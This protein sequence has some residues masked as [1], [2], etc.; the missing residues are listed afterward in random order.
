MKLRML[1][2]ISALIALGSMQSVLADEVVWGN[3]ASSGN[4]NLEAF[5]IN[6]GGVATLV[7][8]Q[9]FLV[10]NLTARVDNGRGVAVLGNT[11]YYTT[12]SS[13]DIYITDAISHADGGILVST[14]FPGIANVATDGTYIYASSYETASGVVNRYTQAG[15]AAGS[16][17]VGTGFGRDGF[18]V[19]NNPFLDGGATT[20]ISNRGDLT[21]PYDVYKADGSLLV[22]AFIDPSANGFGTGQTGIAYDGT[23]YF[24]SDVRNN[25]LFKYSGTGV[26]LQTVDLSGIP[27]PFTGRLLEDLSSVGNT[28]G[29]PGG[30]VPEPTSVLLFGTVLVG[31]GALRRNKRRVNS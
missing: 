3:S 19:Q 12:A 2:A 4:V 23:N 31:I 18:E 6:A 9:Q 17:S 11:I 29:N 25:R 21:S 10:P 28:V 24:V 8:G 1:V 5:S 20:F 27:N 16:V 15:V 30:S 22:S 26:Y 7:P 14:G 13:G